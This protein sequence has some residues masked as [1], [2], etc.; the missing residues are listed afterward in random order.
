MVDD[1]ETE[2]VP[3]LGRSSGGA[4]L[5]PERRPAYRRREPVSGSCEERLNL[6]PDRAEAGEDPASCERETPERQKPP[7]AEYRGGEPGAERPVVAKRPSNAGGA[8]GARY[9]GLEGGQP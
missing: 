2:G 9:P 4:C 7:G 5:P 6:A 8:K 3:Y 1:V